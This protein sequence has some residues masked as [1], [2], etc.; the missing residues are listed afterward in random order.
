MS[1]KYLATSPIMIHETDLGVDDIF[2]GATIPPTNLP[3]DNGG[4]IDLEF[5]GLGLA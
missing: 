5:D 3:I 1:F 4:D 2:G